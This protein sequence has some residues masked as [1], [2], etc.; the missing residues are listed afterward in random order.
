MERYVDLNEITDGRQ[1]SSNDMV[2]A[3]CGDCHGCSACCRGMGNSILLDPLDIH[4]LTSNLS[5]TLEQL[6]QEGKVELNVSDGIILPN[7]KMAG[8]EEVCSFLNEDGRCQIHSFRPGFCRLFPLGRHYEDRTFHYILM[9]HE[10]Q[11]ENRTKVKIHKWIGVED[12]DAYEK[13]VNTWHY[14]LKDLQE[15]M[16]A[17]AD[18]TLAKQISMYVLQKF[19]LEPY[20]DTESFYDEFEK[21]YMDAKQVFGL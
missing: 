16:T 9:I 3:E 17:S 7:L 5:V 11:K 14:M 18:Q 4:R 2:K 12:I 21:R 19:Y 10:C 20:A 1:Y 6:L 15:K 8:G 13:F